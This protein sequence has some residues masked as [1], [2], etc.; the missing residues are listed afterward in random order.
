MIVH[1]A[2]PPEE[3][4]RRLV[5]RRVCGT[6]GVNRLPDAAEGTTCRNCGGSF[7]RRSDDDEAVVRERLVVFREQTEPLVEF[8][9]GRPTCFEVDGD[10]T[11]GQVSQVLRGIVARATA[12]ASAGQVQ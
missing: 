4:V 5:A 10:G 9:R 8:Y 2:V 1:L 7:V 12:E 3:L 6:C 11:I